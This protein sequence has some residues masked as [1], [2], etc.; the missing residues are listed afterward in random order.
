MK[1]C[2]NCLG[3]RDVGDNYCWYCGTKLAAAPIQICPCGRWL[4]PHDIFCPQC[5]KEIEM[6]LNETQGEGKLA[7]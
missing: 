4:N 7:P 1:Y 6:E 5:G 3:L 2:P